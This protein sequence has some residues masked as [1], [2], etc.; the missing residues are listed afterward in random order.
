MI[1]TRFR[2][3][4]ALCL[5][6][7]T[8][9]TARGPL[10]MVPD[11]VAPGETVTIF[12]ASNRDYG[13]FDPPRRGRAT[14]P[15]YSRITMR[16]PDGH[17]IGN[18]RIAGTAP[19]PARHFLVSDSQTF[20]G[21]AGLTN[22]IRREL[23]RLPKNEREV[24][25]FTPGF[26]MS[27]AQSIVRTAQLRH[28]LDLPG[29]TALFSWPSAGSVFGYAYDRDSTLFSRDAFEAYLRAL[30]AAQPDD[31]IL[32]SHS[33][34]AQLTMEVLRQMAA[35]DPAWVQKNI[36]GVVLISPDIDVEVF[37]AQ[38]AR[39]KRLPQPFAI[40]VSANDRALGLSARVSGDGRR[41]GNIT[42]PAELADLD[43]V[44]LDI[45]AF[46]SGMGHFSFG[47]SPALIGIVS[48]LAR[49]ESSFSDDPAARAGLIPGTILTV[50]NATRIILSPV[51]E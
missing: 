33:M 11:G 24:I 45:S 18:V 20:E 10:Q 34:G 13:M 15:A 37:R 47:S 29:V 26:N 22:A 6:V 8:A 12:E 51:A 39:I 5:A 44:L 7:L 14:V 30:A 42:D 17:Q 50:Q 38:V 49:V 40:F 21:Y 2:I 19:D 46:H 3:G 32:V 48:Q 23:S 27:A 4:A 1:S 43:V 41:L 36:G 9:C 16:V 35:T 25:V 28:D 31:L